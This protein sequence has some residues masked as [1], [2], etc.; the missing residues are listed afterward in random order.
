MIIKFSDG[1][2]INTGGKLRKI[3]LPDGYYVV[4]NGVMIPATSSKDASNILNEELKYE[5][6]RG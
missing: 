6:E 4:G 1:R 2:T 5:K 3:K